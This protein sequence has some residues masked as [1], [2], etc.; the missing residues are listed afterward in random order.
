MWM[1]QQE[2][3]QVV[4]FRI[5]GESVVDLDDGCFGV[6]GDLFVTDLGFKIGKMSMT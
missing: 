6:V 4:A 2:F 5:S 1:T 3:V